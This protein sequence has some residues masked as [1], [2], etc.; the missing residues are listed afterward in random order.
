MSCPTQNEYH[1]M[2]QHVNLSK[3]GRVCVWKPTARTADVTKITGYVRVRILMKQWFFRILGI[4]I[5]LCSATFYTLGAHAL[6]TCSARDT[7]VNVCGALRLVGGC[8]HAVTT[9]LGCHCRQGT[10]Q[11]MYIVCNAFWENVSGDAGLRDVRRVMR[12]NGIF[13]PNLLFWLRCNI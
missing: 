6:N 7:T 8:T 4:H 10:T 5:I 1:E 11:V 2:A 12:E 3:C 13:S 9:M